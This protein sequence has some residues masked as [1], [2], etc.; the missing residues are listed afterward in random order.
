MVA[1]LPNH[2]KF[3]WPFLC[4]K[5]TRINDQFN[6]FYGPEFQGFYNYEKADEITSYNVIQSTKTTTYGIGLGF[7]LGFSYSI[8]SNVS[9]SAEIVPNFTYLKSKND[10]ITVNSY[11]F[12]LSN[13]QAGITI[14]YKF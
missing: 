12:E 9:L 7:I 3:H 5:H 11:N 13:Q 2:G 10:D 4:C 8:T 1:N 14:S 6:F